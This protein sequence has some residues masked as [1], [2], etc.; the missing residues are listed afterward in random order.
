MVLEVMNFLEYDLPEV[1]LIF[2][3]GSFEKVKLLVATSHLGLASMK[4]L[5]PQAPE[6][7]MSLYSFAYAEFTILKNLPLFEGARPSEISLA[8]Q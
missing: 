4:F 8:N 7:A 6:N 5:L 3:G 2:I 1:Q